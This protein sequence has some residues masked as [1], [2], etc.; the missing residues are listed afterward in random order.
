MESDATLRIP[1]EPAVQGFA[2]LEG[3]RP[4]LRRFPSSA[5]ALVLLARKHSNR[6]DDSEAIRLLQQAVYCEPDH[7]NAYELLA[8]IYSELGQ[9]DDAQKLYKAWAISAFQR[10][11]REVRGQ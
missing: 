2:H 5:I 3:A 7:D 9:R 8:E 6:G 10:R 11:E 1:G 4:S